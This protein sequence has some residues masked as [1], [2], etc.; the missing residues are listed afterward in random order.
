MAYDDALRRA[1]RTGWHCVPDRIAPLARGLT[2]LTWLVAVDG[3]EYVAKL[4]PAQRR[5]HFEAGLAAAHH[6]LTRGIDA[7]AP[8][9]TLAGRLVVDLAE[10]ALALLRRVPGGTGRTGVIDWGSAASGPL[11]FD[12]ASAVMYAG[13]PD[14]A[15]DL[16][17]GYAAAG[18]VPRDEIETTLPVLLRFRW[19]AQADWFARRI[20]EADVTGVRDAADNLAGL[21]AARDALA[22]IAC[23]ER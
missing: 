15:G 6:L 1:L 12:V 5:A 11:M 10:G 7:G 9:R 8:V 21:H 2:S 4:V 19:A 3:E 23:V 17:D 16:L 18:P 14:V 22:R 20:H 13:G